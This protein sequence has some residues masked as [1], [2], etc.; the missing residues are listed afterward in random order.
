MFTIKK[1]TRTVVEMSV[2]A[3]L[4]GTIMSC[5]KKKAGSAA[6]ATAPAAN[7]DVNGTCTVGQNYASGV[8]F[9]TAIGQA[10]YGNN[11]SVVAKFAFYGKNAAGLNMTSNPVTYSGAFDVTGTVRLSDGQYYGVSTT[12]TRMVSNSVNFSL[13]AGFTLPSWQINAGYGY[14]GGY[15]GG[16]NYGGGYYLP[17]RTNCYGG[18]YNG[19]YNGGNN[20]GYNGGYNGGNNG[21]YGGQCQIPVGDY[22]V[23]TVQSGNYNSSNGYNN[24]ES[25]TNLKIRFQS[26]STIVDATIPQGYLQS[27]YQQQSSSSHILRG[28][29]VINTVNNQQCNQRIQF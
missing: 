12:A 9:R 16:N 2:L 26:G 28:Q 5:G 23:T 22:T 6:V 1:I 13:N 19:G 27:G 21:G 17:C 18:G 7:C 20:G 14:G 15:N 25:F 8:Y 10:R 11:Q 29:M 4:A 3:V 24:T